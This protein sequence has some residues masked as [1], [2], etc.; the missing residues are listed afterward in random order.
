[1]VLMMV[2]N[3]DTRTIKPEERADVAM[4]PCPILFPVIMEMKYVHGAETDYPLE[5]DG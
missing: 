4:L 3:S 1:M 2:H 5:F